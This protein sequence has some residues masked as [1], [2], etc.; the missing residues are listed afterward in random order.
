MVEYIV[1]WKEATESTWHKLVSP[2]PISY[3]QNITPPSFKAGQ[4]AGVHY[5]LQLIEDQLA[6]DA[7]CNPNQGNGGI[8][9]TGSLVGPIT[10]VDVYV[11][12]QGCGRN[13]YIWEFYNSRGEGRGRTTLDSFSFRF[14]TRP[15][16]VRL[17]RT[18]G[19]IDTCGSAVAGS[20]ETKFVSNGQ[21][22]ATIT[23]AECVL[24]SESNPN[25]CDCC[26]EM[27]PKANSILSR[28]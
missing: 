20:C 2:Y 11:H 24:V 3:T 6:F 19:Q 25:E 27:I 15:P 22:I 21:T 1:F 17:V 26:E 18:D 10:K 14:L 28:L 23:K 4:C 13:S 7:N 16:T 12:T 8:S 5:V 9:Q